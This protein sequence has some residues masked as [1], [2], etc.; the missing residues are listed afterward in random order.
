MRAQAV[1]RGRQAGSQSGEKINRIYLTGLLL[2]CYFLI[3]EM[4]HQANHRT[5]ALI[6]VAKGRPAS[7]VLVVVSVRIIV[8]PRS[9]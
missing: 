1:G 2:L 9:G 5:L 7:A 8:P 6:P 4:N 3:L